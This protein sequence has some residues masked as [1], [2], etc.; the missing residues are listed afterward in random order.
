MTDYFIEVCLTLG[1]KI[2]TLFDVRTDLRQNKL[3]VNF[4]VAFNKGLAK[5]CWN[6]SPTLFHNNVV[7]FNDVT[8]MGWDGCISSDSILFHLLDEVSF[9][10][11]SRGFSACLNYSSALDINNITNLQLRDFFVGMKL[12]RHDFQKAKL[13][14][15]LSFELE[16]LFTDQQLSSDALI[17]SVFANA[18]QKVGRNVLVYPKFS[19]VELTW[20]SS[21]D[22][23]DWWMVSSIVAL[24]WSLEAILEEISGKFTVLFVVL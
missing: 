8:D 14:D 6:K 24:P 12:P 1:D 3:R 4:T 15:V 23:S 2:T 9:C 11:V 16:E 7:T 10:Q 21:P 22:R 13:N 18:C 20:L 17:R 19:V 5:L